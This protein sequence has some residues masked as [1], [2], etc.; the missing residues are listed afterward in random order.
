[1]ANKKIP[2]SIR[3]SSKYVKTESCWIWTGAKKPTGYGNFWMNEKYLGAHCAAYL[4]FKGEIPDGMYVC[5]KCDNP[6][7]VNPDHLFVALPIDNTTDMKNKGRARGIIQGS[8]Y[9]PGRKISHE[10]AIKI[11][12][13]RNSGE[14]LRVIA[15]DYGVS[16]ATI[17]YVS[18]G[19]IWKDSFNV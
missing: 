10:I 14:L 1:M 15:K 9:H 5:H 13:R 11:R 8:E 16:E 3:F 7:C 6:E 12:I 19:K 17:C 18:Q 2:A 4:L